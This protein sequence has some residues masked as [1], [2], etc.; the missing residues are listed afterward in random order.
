MLFP[1]EKFP[2]FAGLSPE[3][4]A[5]LRG[6]AKE[7]RALPGATIVREGEAGNAMFLLGEGKVEIR[8]SDSQGRAIRLAELEPGSFFGEMCILETLPRVATIIA[9]TDVS[10]YSL[11][12]MDYYKFYHAM[13]AQYSILVL[14]IARD[15]SRRLRKLEEQFVRSGLGA[16]SEKPALQ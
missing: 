6:Q 10:L 3:A 8:K 7:L 13:P 5:F 15:L 2:I 14:N 16:L 1:W 9:L 4:L 12:S 11:S